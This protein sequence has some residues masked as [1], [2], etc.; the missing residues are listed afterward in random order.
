VRRR[1]LRVAV[2][3]AG[4]AGL[5]AA[6]TLRE[7]GHSVTVFEAGEVAGGRTHTEHFGSGHYSDTGAGWLASFYPGTLALFD[8]LGERDRLVP[9]SI[10]G[11]GD[12]LLDGELVPAPNSLRRIVSTRLLSTA[13][14]ARFLS[15]MAALMVRQRGDLAVDMRYDAVRAL[16][17]L[18]PAGKGGIE[19]VVRPLFEGPFFARLDQMSALLVRS[20]LRVLAVGSFYAVD[21]GMDAPWRALADELGVATATPVAGVREH[22]GQAELDLGDRTEVFDCAVVAVPAPVAAELVPAGPNAAVLS[23]VKYAPH[24][25]LHAARRRD[26]GEVPAPRSGIHAFPN[27]TVATVELSGGAAGSWGRTPDD[28]DWLL[29]CSPAATSGALL[30][31][32][33]AAARARLWSEAR[34]VD[35]RI[36]PL[37]EADVVHLV[38][39]PHAVPIVDPGYHTRLTWLEQKPP[40]VFCGDWLVQPCVEGA[41]RSGLRAAELVDLA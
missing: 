28:H 12:L 17:A 25:R 35:P 4:P 34:R 10:R 14:K 15:F 41:V 39:W 32:D 26:A 33:E 24:V 3:G 5:T 37:D 11:G 19:R 2:V 38:R 36:F 30:A 21:G 6:H 22:S 29:V 23:R 13:E 9:M 8:E 16:D 31:L 20:W 1:G 7:R 27:D 18:A 40:I